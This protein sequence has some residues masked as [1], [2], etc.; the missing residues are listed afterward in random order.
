[1]YKLLIMDLLSQDV[2]EI[3]CKI[4]PRVHDELPIQC[5]PFPKVKF[6]CVNVQSDK[7][8]LYQSI[9]NKI[10]DVESWLTNDYIDSI[11]AFVTIGL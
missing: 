4:I 1:M 10:P 7:N 9:K 2:F 6:V 3:K 5:F 11:D 8:I